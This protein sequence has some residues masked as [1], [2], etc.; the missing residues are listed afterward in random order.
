MSNKDASDQTAD[1]AQVRVENIEETD[2]FHKL[3]FLRASEPSKAATARVLALILTVSFAGVLLL[4]FSVGVYILRKAPAIDD[5]TLAAATEFLKVTSAIF[6]PLLA[7]IL[8][9]YFSK[10]ED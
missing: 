6:S 2:Q 7:F 4:S 1:R 8:G 9:Y 3:R 10:R 5:K